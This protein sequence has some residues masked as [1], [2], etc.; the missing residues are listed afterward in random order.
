M[1]TKD[2]KKTTTCQ[3]LKQ[4]VYT[5]QPS[6]GMGILTFVSRLREWNFLKGNCLQVWWSCCLSYNWTASSFS[7]VLTFRIFSTSSSSSM[8]REHR[9]CVPTVK[10]VNQLS[11]FYSDPLLHEQR[12]QT[13]MNINVL[14]ID[15]QEFLDIRWKAGR[16]LAHGKF[17]F[18]LS[19]GRCSPGIQRTR[20]SCSASFNFHDEL[21]L[22]PASTKPSI[23]NAWT[24]P[25]MRSLCSVIDVIEEW[26]TRWCHQLVLLKNISII[27][28]GF[29]HRSQN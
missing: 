3:K 12:C 27:M 26:M 17:F 23:I 10:V 22:F 5:E 28:N 8:N 4:I 14:Y 29:L 15:W 2:Q 1:Q 25:E 9:L 18:F 11:I 21:D 13:M 6:D 16:N 24:N 7:L 19:F 20:W